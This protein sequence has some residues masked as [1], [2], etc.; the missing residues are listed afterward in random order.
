MIDLFAAH[1]AVLSHIFGQHRQ[2]LA[3]ADPAAFNEAD[4][5]PHMLEHQRAGS[6]RADFGSGGAGLTGGGLGCR[7]LRALATS[8]LIELALLPFAPWIT[9]VGD[10]APNGLRSAMRLPTTKGAPHF[11]ALHGVARMRYKE[12][13][14]LPTTSPAASQVRLGAQNRSQNKIIFQHQGRYRALTI[15]A[16]PKFKMFRNRYCKKPKLWLRMLTLDLILP[17]YRTDAQVSSR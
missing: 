12:N 10:A 2:H 7:S 17:S 15:P 8:A 3:A 5:H 13:A 6:G 4:Y 16:W 1:Q 9:V 11:V 14:A